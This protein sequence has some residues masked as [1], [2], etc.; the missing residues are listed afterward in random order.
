MNV[1]FVVVVFNHNQSEMRNFRMRMV[2]ACF[3]PSFSHWK[4]VTSIWVSEYSQY[5][6]PSWPFKPASVGGTFKAE[7]LTLHHHPLCT[8]CPQLREQRESVGKKILNGPRILVCSSCYP[9]KSQ[10][11]GLAWTKGKHVSVGQIFLLSKW[12]SFPQ[13]CLKR[14]S[15]YRPFQRL[16]SAGAPCRGLTKVQF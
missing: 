10:T 16:I 5:T 8:F 6:T 15:T 1:F 11:M 9:L 7:T 13:R 4:N 14:N 12:F 2:V 3:S